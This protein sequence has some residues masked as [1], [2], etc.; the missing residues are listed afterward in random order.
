MLTDFDQQQ[1]SNLNT[2]FEWP[3]QELL[4]EYFSFEIE[5]S[6]HKL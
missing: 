3:Y 2:S 1:N 5:Q 6:K 4:N